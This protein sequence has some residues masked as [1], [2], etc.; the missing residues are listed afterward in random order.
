MIS[1]VIV[2]KIEYKGENRLKLKFAY[3]ANA[4]NAINKL[5]VSVWS[6]TL[7]S[8]LM[9]FNKASVEALRDIFSEIEFEHEASSIQTL[10]EESNTKEE[11]LI[12]E[13]ADYLY[14]KVNMIN[15]NDKTFLSGIELNRNYQSS[16]YWKI[17]NSL[18][19]NSLIKNHF[20]NRLRQ[21]PS[22]KD[23]IKYYEEKLQ[24]RNKITAVVI[25][26]MVR[27]IFGRNKLVIDFL[28]AMPF[29]SW[30]PGNSWWT[31]AYNERSLKAFKDF[32]MENK[33]DL[34]ID[35]VSALKRLSKRSIDYHDPTHRKCPSEMIEKLTNRRYSK[36]TI[37]QYCSMFEEFINYHR[38]LALEELGTP[39]IKEF[40]GYLV[41]ERRV[42]TSYQNL[43]V[44]AIK[45]YYE[46]VLGGPRRIIDFDR[47][48]RE[49]TLP[50][51]LSRE[52][53]ISMLSAVT[54]PKH[55]FILILLYSTGIRRGELL[56][57]KPGDIDRDNMQIW[58]RGGKGKKD[59][60][61]QLGKSVLTFMDEYIGLYNP[62]EYLIEGLREKYSA[63]SVAE[64]I[65]TAAKKAGIT[66]RVTAHKFRHSYATHMLEDGVDTRFIQE[67]LGHESIKTT[68]IYSHV[69][70]KNIKNLSNPFDKLKI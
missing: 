12:W 35:H 13:D 69:T 25:S 39:E 32:C 53:V 70:D 7:K 2:S 44:N 47:P 59:R 50:E 54:N 66:R 3:N 48:R 34:T 43:A 31:F 24:N 5:A 65:K 64:I 33:F 56:Q 19:T 55:K 38:K 26:N 17:K 40:I 23:E 14:I 46:K 49:K 10:R 27:V 29:H 4:G 37:R 22:L 1:K 28:K 63:T 60:Y 42:S 41:Q 61:V 45:F 52:E 67:L 62:K 68:Q 16:G 11:V 8:W 51:V 18:S 58:I 57:L 30:D 6:E 20:S 36:S 9:P 21:W 15:W